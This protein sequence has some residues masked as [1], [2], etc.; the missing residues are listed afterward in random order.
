M[1]IENAGLYP[2]LSAHENM[3]LYGLC[4]GL[5]DTEKKVSESLDLVG[6]SQ[7]G[8]KNKAFF[9]GHETATWNRHGDFGQAGA[10]GVGRAYQRP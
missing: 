9:Y 3:M 6:L 5:T 4:I 2:G 1:L 7:T 8:K 10:F